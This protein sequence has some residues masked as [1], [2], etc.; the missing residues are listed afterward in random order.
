VI[1]EGAGAGATEG[2]GVATEKADTG[3]G[4]GKNVG[5]G[6][7]ADV[8][9]GL[10]CTGLTLEGDHIHRLWKNTLTLGALFCIH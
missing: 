5:A 9:E 1:V 7:G 8:T 6:A 4:A 10:Q 3:A 2:A